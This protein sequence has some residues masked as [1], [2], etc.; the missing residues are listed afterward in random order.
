MGQCK[1]EQGAKRDTAGID[2]GIFL[3]ELRHMVEADGRCF[4]GVFASVDQRI[5]LANADPHCG[6][7]WAVIP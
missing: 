1:Y 5:I 4:W 2:L 6:K 3:R 7:I